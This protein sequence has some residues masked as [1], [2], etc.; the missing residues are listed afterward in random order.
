MAA[1]Q[2]GISVGSHSV[3]AV[4]VRKKGEGYAVLRAVSRRLDAESRPE[5]GRWLASKGI[6]GPAMV[7][8][9]GRDVIIRYSQVPPVPDWRLKNLMKFEV[10]EVSSQSGGAV[11]AD[12]RKLDLPDPEGTRS[13]ETVLVALARNQYLEPL[14]SSLEGAGVKVAGG[15]PASV[16][17]FNAFAVNATYPEDE[18]CLLVNVGAQGLDVAVERGGELIFARNASPGGKAFTDAIASAFGTTEAKAETLKVTKADVTPRG[19]AR[20]PDPTAEKVANAIMGVAGQVAALIQSTLLVA[21]AQTKLPDLKVDRVRLTGGGASM[22]GLDA[23]LKQAMGVPV[24]RLDPFEGCDLD[25]L[26]AEERQALEAAPHEFAVALGL[27]QTQTAPAAFRLEVLP[28]GVRKKRDFA[29][30][31]VFAIAAGAVAAVAL[32]ILYTARKSASEAN[33]AQAKVLEAAAATSNA[34]NGD[35]RDAVAR[36][37]DQE[38]KHRRLAELAAPGILA[39]EALALL[40]SRMP[41]EIHLSEVALRVVDQPTE[42]RL[43]VPSGA[44]NAQGTWTTTTFTR[45]V[46]R[47]TVLATAYVAPGPRPAQVYQQFVTELQSNDRGLVV[48]PTGTLAQ[49]GKFALEVARGVSFR[50]EGAEEAGWTLAQPRLV[51]A[52]GAAEATAV[53]GTTVDGIETTVPLAEVHPDDRKRLL[54]TLPAPAAAPTEG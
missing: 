11:S 44:K 23:Y 26:P 5:A 43:L 16:A 47:A 14:F 49:D 37:Q 41:P 33:E 31:G 22:K 13:D 36:A 2:T 50:K 17:L 45:P 9:S 19:Q 54:E 18:T 34:L 40:V 42:H 3:R 52:D 6:A 1:A 38:Q 39:S 21:R 24:D 30:K 15:C 27:A 35:F 51:A 28:E 12:Y 10:D 20:Y 46:R 8:L 29:T 7:S 32:V 25:A 4:V 53:V 48:S